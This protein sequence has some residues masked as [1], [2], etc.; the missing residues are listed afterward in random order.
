[1]GLTIIFVLDNMSVYE[2]LSFPSIYIDE[3]F[4]E[5][6]W[7]VVSCIGWVFTRLTKR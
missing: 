6:N 7:S 3:K 1:M 4:D 5:C 2:Q